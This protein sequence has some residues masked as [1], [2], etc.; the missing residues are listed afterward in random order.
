[1]NL[2][3]ALLVLTVPL[4][5][6]RSSEDENAR[7]W[8]ETS[9]RWTYEC[10]ESD[11]AYWQCIIDA[12][13]P[14]RDTRSWQISPPGT[15]IRVSNTCIVQVVLSQH[16]IDQPT[17]LRDRVYREAYA[18]MWVVRPSASGRLEDGILLRDNTIW[19]DRRPDGSQRF[20]LYVWQ[21]YSPWPELPHRPP[22]GPGEIDVR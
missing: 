13:G 9:S 3:L 1:M 8:R 10:Y 19:Q 22:E 12:I 11:E 21:H 15:R 17:L 16:W 6:D 4:A 2:V 18:G 5:G 7:L 14:R 20:N